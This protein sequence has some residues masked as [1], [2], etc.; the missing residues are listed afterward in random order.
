V[1]RHEA[2]LLWRLIIELRRQ[3]Y[4]AA[5]NIALSM[6]LDAQRDFNKEDRANTEQELRDD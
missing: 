6:L 1:T 4:K 5:E 3:R 2:E